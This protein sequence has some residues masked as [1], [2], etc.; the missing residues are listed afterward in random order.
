[1]N[2]NDFAGSVGQGLSLKRT[3]TGIIKRTKSQIKV[4]FYKGKINSSTYHWINITSI[5]TD[6]QTDSQAIKFTPYQ[7]LPHIT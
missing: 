1:M 6:E 3:G 4:T 5:Q 2:W 7:Q